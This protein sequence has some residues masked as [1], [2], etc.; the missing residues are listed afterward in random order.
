MTG[1]LPP[2]VVLTGCGHMGLAIAQGLLRSPDAPAVVAVERDAGRRE[3]LAD[4]AGLTVTDVL[5]PAPGDLVVLAVPPQDFDALAD[6]SRDVLHPGQP[7]LS[8]MAGVTA[9]RIAQALGTDEVVRAIPNTPSEVFGGMSVWYALPAATAVV[10]QA[11]ALLGTIG[12]ALRVEREELVDD[13]TAICGGGPAFVSYIVDAFCRFGEDRGF[14][15][16]ESR[17]MAAQV[18]SG[19]AALIA[20]SSKPPM[21]L[22]RE[23]MTAG[24]T[25]ERGIA[26]FEA[27]ELTATVSSA[28]AAS[29]GRSR[30]LAG[31]LA[32]A[33]PSA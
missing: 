19:S 3:V 25:T 17:F 15:P 18:F 30:E 21:Q 33:P 13:A 26:V 23:V 31:A 12:K 22:C 1:G 32:G 24:G 28:L 2:R 4:V 16:D 9:A 20:G 10:A 11:E 14:S 5:A 29:A 8:V 7:V 6:A 27:A